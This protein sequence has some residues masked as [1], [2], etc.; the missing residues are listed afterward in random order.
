MKPHIPDDPTEADVK[1]LLGAMVTIFSSAGLHQL[2]S[3]VV[4]EEDLPAEIRAEAAKRNTQFI[5]NAGNNEYFLGYKGDNFFNPEPI[6][7]PPPADPVGRAERKARY[8][9]PGPKGLDV[10]SLARIATA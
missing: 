7:I 3:M 1:A 4:W 5:M 6:F 8:I 2:A 9:L 10:F